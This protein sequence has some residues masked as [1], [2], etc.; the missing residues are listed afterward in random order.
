MNV[1]ENKEEFMITIEEALSWLNHFDRSH[2][3]RSTRSLLRHMKSSYVSENKRRMMISTAI[4]YARSNADPF[5]LPEVLL[6]CSVES[7]SQEDY[8]V[9]KDFAKAALQIYPPQSNSMGVTQWIL[10]IIYRKIPNNSLGYPYWYRA[11]KIFEV[12]KAQAADLRN[13]EMAGWYAKCLEKMNI[14]MLCTVE[15][16]YTWLDY[17]EASH[18]SSEARFL[19]ERLIREL[20]DNQWLDARLSIHDL[21]SLGES[22][23]DPRETAEALVECGLAAYRM[24]EIDETL[25]LLRKAIDILNPESLQQAAAHWMLGTIQ[26]QREK[27]QELAGANWRNSI[28]TFEELLQAQDDG[29]QQEQLTW[30]RKSV[31]YMTLALNNKLAEG[32]C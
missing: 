10:G 31:Q 16:P 21:Q 8:A 32:N 4:Q 29:S 12:L 18:L 17:F 26:W 19:S 25:G 5:E 7:Y 27:S 6:H 13:S 9:A 3:R 15:E 28:Q 24:G 14:A 2:L 20:G 22:S 23:L 11:R 1:A 30:Y